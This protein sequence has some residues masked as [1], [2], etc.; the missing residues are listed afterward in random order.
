MPG[1]GSRSPSSS[2][3]STDGPVDLAAEEGYRKLLV[4]MAQQLVG[5]TSMVVRAV[6]GRRRPLPAGVWIADPDDRKAIGAPLAR[7]AAR[8][9]PM[10]GK[11]SDDLVDGFT[12]GV[13]GIGYALKGFEAETEALDIEA[14]LVDGQALADVP[15]LYRNPAISVDEP[16]PPPQL[17]ADILEQR[18]RR[19]DPFPG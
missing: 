11:G 13:A 18:A 8:H 6:R 4:E 1:P 9:A 2:L 16:S 3:G 5:L 14:E 10:S 17:L 7:I 19:P 12:A 15:P